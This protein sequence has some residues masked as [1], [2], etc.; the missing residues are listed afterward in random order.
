MSDRVKKVPPEDFDKYKK[1]GEVL[2][3][4]YDAEDEKSKKCAKECAEFIVKNKAWTG[5][6]LDYTWK[7]QWQQEN[8][9]CASKAIAWVSNGKV[10]DLGS[11][12]DLSILMK[13][14]N[15]RDSKPTQ[16]GDYEKTEKR[17]NDANNDEEAGPS[18]KKK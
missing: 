7:V 3:W 16:K 17:K 14:Y 15:H 1:N 10:K 8:G 18:K 2:V 11:N 12:K 9:L 13:K 5:I 4:R 6:Q